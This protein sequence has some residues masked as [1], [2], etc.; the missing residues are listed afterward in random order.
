MKYLFHPFS[1]S[2]AK[3]GQEGLGSGL[4]ISYEIFKANGG[5]IG[6]KS[7][8]QEMIY[9]NYLILLVYRQTKVK[10]RTFSTF[11]FHPYFPIM[12]PDNLWT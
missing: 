3:D 12:L 5:N 7:D 8:E 4:Y 6:V 2:N 9:R 11:T 1:R 10:G